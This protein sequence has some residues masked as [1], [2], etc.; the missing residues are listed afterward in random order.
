MAVPEQLQVRTEYI[1]CKYINVLAI[2]GDGNQS[3]GREN[4]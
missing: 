4:C 3:T 1:Y 2:A